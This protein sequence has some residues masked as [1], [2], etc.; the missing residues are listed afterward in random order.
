MMAI[1][2]FSIEGVSVLTPNPCTLSAGWLIY[3]FE[4]TGELNWFE[5]EEIYI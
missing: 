1:V 2:C 3:T 4:V 5:G